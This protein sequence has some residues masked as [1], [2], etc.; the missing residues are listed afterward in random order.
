MHTAFVRRS[1]V[2]A[3]SLLLLAACDRGPKDVVGKE[4]LEPLKEGMSVAEVTSVIGKGPLTS[5]QPGDSLRLVSGFRTQLF[6]AGGARYRV[7]WYREA[8]GTV[9]DAI[10]RARE[11]PILFKDEKVM[12]HGWSFFDK[13]A[14]EVG[15]PN[16]YVD[17]LKA[18]SIAKRQGAAG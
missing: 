11:T 13:T 12:G 7:I 10:S 8:E 4:K 17:E 2:L 5:F 14:R 15:L 6:L 16:P 18:D 9:E 1:L 3:G